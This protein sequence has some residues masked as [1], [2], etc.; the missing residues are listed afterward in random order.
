MRAALPPP[1]NPNEFS[2]NANAAARGV[3]T[4]IALSL[5]NASNSIKRLSPPAGNN[6]ISDMMSGTADFYGQAA[7][8]WGAT[9]AYPALWLWFSRGTG[10][11]GSNVWGS[12]LHIPGG[13]AQVGQS[14][15]MSPYSV[16]QRNIH[17]YLNAAR[18]L[19]T[20]TNST[21]DSQ[22]YLV[23]R[24]PFYNSLMSFV[25]NTTNAGQFATITPT[26]IGTN[27]MGQVVYETD[28]FWLTLGSI[29]DQW[30]VG[31]TNQAGSMMGGILGG[32]GNSKPYYISANYGMP[33]E[34]VIWQHAYLAIDQR[35][36]TN[37]SQPLAIGFHIW[38]NNVGHITNVNWRWGLVHDVRTGNTFL[39]N[40]LL[41]SSN[42]IVSGT[43]GNTFVTGGNYGSGAHNI[44]NGS[45]MFNF[46]AAYGDVNQ[47][48]TFGYDGESTLGYGLQSGKKPQ[49]LY[50]TAWGL[51]VAQANVA[52]L[53][54]GK[55]TQ[56]WTN[57]LML[58]NN[59]FT[60]LTPFV[61]TNATASNL[62]PFRVSAAGIAS[63]LVVNSNG[64]AGV[65]LISPGAKLSVG[66]RI[67]V[68][69][70]GAPTSLQGFE[71]GF[72][73]SV[74]EGIFAAYD[75][76]NSLFEQV[77]LSGSNLVFQTARGAQAT[78][79]M[80]ITHD[81][82]VG[83]GTNAP[84]ARLQVTADNSQQNVIIAGTSNSPTAWRLDTNGNVTIS[85]GQTNTGDMVA[86]DFWTGV[87]RV[88]YLRTTVEG[89]SSPNTRVIQIGSGHIRLNFGS[90]DSS[91]ARASFS[92]T[93]GHIAV[94]GTDGLLGSA[95]TNLL[96]HGGTTNLVAGTA[97]NMNTQCG[98]VLIASGSQSYFVTNNNITANS[99]VT[100]AV[101]SDDATA[102]SAKAI[103]TAGLLQLKL[104]GVAAANT[105]I[106]FFIARP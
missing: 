14:W 69:S 20:S 106:S 44:L 66:G 1:I 68:E 37:A 47:D 2:T 72:D 57:Q 18:N 54:V 91:A 82:N 73:P 104:N 49:L 4:N 35:G 60:V 33:L 58:S 25:V 87:G 78:N 96:I 5:V 92:T 53:Q 89:I 7:L 97:T 80:I 70:N 45:T 88:V 77:R 12:V 86:R 40:S 16:N 74:P 76:D 56:V 100:T 61:A 90:D 27:T 43:N 51:N 6:E 101:N 30:S 71:I 32:V 98:Q 65:N 26:I 34:T 63:A 23:Q 29:S 31:E 64:N 15:N 17:W 50:S 3:V 93:N 28:P 36:V 52:N 48:V 8:S 39:T 94:T 81:G 85:G 75:R 9:N 99:I 95:N 11:F 55:S 103:C 38:S 105:L 62:P 19:A 79:R 46:P 10:A 67:R 59:T 22:F 84:A 83:I 42:I 21:G 13:L 102:V 41:T 24:S